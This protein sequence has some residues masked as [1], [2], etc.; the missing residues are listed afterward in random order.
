VVGAVI[1]LV[2]ILVPPTDLA[3]PI[4]AIAVV[5]SLMVTGSVSAHLGR[6]PKLPAVALVVA[7]GL[8]AKAASTDGRH[9][10]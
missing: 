2:A 9:A 10:G 6:A 5:L 4:T 3:V 8:A 1:P 7:G